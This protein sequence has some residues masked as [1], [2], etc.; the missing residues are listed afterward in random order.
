[1]EKIFEIGKQFRNEGLSSTHYIEFT[2]CELYEAY[3]SLD[4]LFSF[5]EEFLCE[6]TRKICGQP[7]TV[8]QGVKL[9]FNPPYRRIEVVPFL[10]EK[11][12]QTLPLTIGK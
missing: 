11:L 4:D 12:C 5:T 7:S 10:E 6:L 9:H 2:T 8:Y 1:M 3:T